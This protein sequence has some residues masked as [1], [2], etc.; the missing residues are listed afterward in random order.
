MDASRRP[1]GFAARF[2]RANPELFAKGPAAA[3]VPP[4][5]LASPWRPHVRAAGSCAVSARA[6]PPSVPTGCATACWSSSPASGC[7]RPKARPI[8][9]SCR[10]RR[11]EDRR[12]AA[13]LPR[14]TDGV[15]PASELAA[16]ARGVRTCAPGTGGA[17][18][19]VAHALPAVRRQRPAHRT[20]SSIVRCLRAGRACHCDKRRLRSR[21]PPP[22]EEHVWNLQSRGIRVAPPQFITIPPTAAPNFRRE[23]SSL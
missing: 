1:D 3:P 22:A 16:A 5:Q 17:V 13:A 23:W 4:G 20:C 7:S 18:I 11:R 2:A 10:W 6:A 19:G 12:R 8:R 21:P 9:M 15:R 14:A